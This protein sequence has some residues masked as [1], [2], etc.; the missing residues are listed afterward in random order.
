MAA[1]GTRY[2]VTLSPP[3]EE[4]LEELTKEL[5]TTK[6]EVLRRSIMFFKHAIRAD[7]V[8]LHRNKDGKDISQE[9]L[10]R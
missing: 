2:S 10:L 8:E 1:Q 7:K 5:H 3:M 4:D 9:V 6:A